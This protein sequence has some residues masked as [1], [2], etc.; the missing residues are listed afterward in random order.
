[1]WAA[2]VMGEVIPF[3]GKAKEPLNDSVMAIM[4][5]KIYPGK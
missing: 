5:T 3:C 4:G 2:Q 1:M